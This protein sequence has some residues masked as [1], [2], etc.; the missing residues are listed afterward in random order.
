M[1]KEA[2]RTNRRERPLAPLLPKDFVDRAPTDRGADALMDWFDNNHLHDAIRQEVDAR[3]DYLPPLQQLGPVLRDHVEHSLA[4][5]TRVVTQLLWRYADVRHEMIT[6]HDPEKAYWREQSR[7][8]MPPELRQ[9]RVKPGRIE[10]L[11]ERQ[12]AFE[13]LISALGLD[14]E[15][16]VIDYLFEEASAIAPPM[17][18][19]PALPS[20]VGRPERAQVGP[21]PR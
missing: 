10:R 9:R 5:Q 11:K 20:A 14:A 1:S 6:Y 15:R 16:A 19:T 3:L 17:S 18:A 13:Q 7:A 8:K 12:L 21:R 2:V 4:Y